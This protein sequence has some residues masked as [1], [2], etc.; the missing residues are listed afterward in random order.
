MRRPLAVVGA[1]LLL[2]LLLQPV[3]TVRR[4]GSTGEARV[5]AGVVAK[6]FIRVYVDGALAAEQEMRSFVWYFAPLSLGAR[7]FATP[8]TA[9]W[10]T[11]EERAWGVGDIAPEEYRATVVAVKDSKGSQWGSAAAPPPVFSESGFTV[12]ATFTAPYDTNVSITEISQPVLEFFHVDDSLLVT[13]DYMLMVRD[14]MSQPVYVGSGSPVTVTYDFVFTSDQPEGRYEIFTY[15]WYRVFAAWLYNTENGRVY[16]TAT[17]GSQVLVDPTRPSYKDPAR[18]V[19]VDTFIV[20]GD[21]QA[22][23]SKSAYRVAHEVARAEPEV[24]RDAHPPHPGSV[25][26]TR[27]FVLDRDVNVTEVAVYVKLTDGKE[28]MLLYYVPDEPVA[29]KAGQPFT[30]TFRV[31]LAPGL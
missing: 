24:M 22:S 21:G 9:E 29:V 13:Y 11:E 19:P 15:N 30:V 6:G 16:V 3:P 12:S 20:V 28:V 10:A 18:N 4:G 17:D 27:T 5:R 14:C 8:W 2:A 23:F 25:V 7:V 1:L 31:Y 26:V